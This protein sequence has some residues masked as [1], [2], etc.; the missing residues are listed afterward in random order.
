MLWR[1]L[2]DYGGAPAA[3]RFA[4]NVWVSGWL[5]ADGVERVV[6][7][8]EA[9]KQTPMSL[10]HMFAA[11]WQQANSQR[12]ALKGHPDHPS[13]YQEAAAYMAWC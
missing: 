6:V 1:P 7:P 11:I 13:C 10:E 8:L 2:S 5:A 4:D 3:A 12:F 9:Q